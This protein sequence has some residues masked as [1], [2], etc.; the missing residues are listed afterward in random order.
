MRAFCYD[1]ELTL[2]YLNAP[3]ACRSRLKT[4]NPI[5]RFI[6][7]LDR[8]FERVGIFP[9]SASWERCTWAVWTELKTN[10]YAPTQPPPHHSTF[11]R[12]T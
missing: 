6:R 9:S 8:K 10:G 4:T 1:F 11:T 7:E 3:P 2:T 5:E 12:T